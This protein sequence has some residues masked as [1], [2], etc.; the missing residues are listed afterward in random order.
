MGFRVDRDAQ[1]RFEER[2]VME[3]RLL[4]KK[5]SS[6]DFARTKGLRLAQKTALQLR[7]RSNRKREKKKALRAYREMV[8]KSGNKFEND[9]LWRSHQILH[10]QVLTKLNGRMQ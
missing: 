7:R 9:T 1:R 4:E 5:R 3:A 6:S 2:Q 8:N 10:D